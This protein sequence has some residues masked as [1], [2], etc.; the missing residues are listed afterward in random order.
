MTLVI[1][2]GSSQFTRLGISATRRLG[3]AVERNSVKRRIREIFRQGRPTVAADIVVIP[4][5]ASLDASFEELAAEFGA[6]VRTQ[7]RRRAPS[8]QMKP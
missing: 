2:R 3:N 5:P 6:L 8:P 1:L 4:R 7:P